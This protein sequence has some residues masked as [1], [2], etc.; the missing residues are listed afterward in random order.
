M[1]ESPLGC[2]RHA[3]RR[4]FGLLVTLG[5]GILLAAI[6]FGGFSLVFFHDVESTWEKHA[7]RATAI[8]DALTDLTEQIGYGGFIH[9]F[10]NLVLRRDLPRYEKRIE[11]NIT[12]LRQALD[13]LD[14][15]LPDPADQADL[16]TLRRTFEE[17]IRKYR[18]IP[19]MVREGATSTQL[20]TVVK[21]DDG[22]AFAALENLSTRVALRALKTRQMA[23]DTYS[24]AMSFDVIAGFLLIAVTLGALAGLLVFFRQLI[25]ANEEARYANAAKSEFLSS[26]SHELRTPLNAIL[27]F[28]QMLRIPD[29]SPLTPQQADNVKEIQ[30][31]GE[32]L[33]DLV[34]EVLDL[35]RIESGRIELSLEP[36]TITPLVTECVAQFRPL[37]EQ[38][39]ITIRMEGFTNN[40]AAHA[41]RARLKQVLLNLLSNAIKYNRECG[42]VMISA[43]T[44]EGQLRLSVM[45]T[46]LGIPPG[47]RTRLFKPFERLGA[48]YDGIEGTGIGLALVKRLVHA[49]GGEIGLESQVGTGSTF[50]FSLPIAPSQLNADDDSTG[51]GWSENHRLPEDSST[52]SQSAIGCAPSC[53]YDL[54]YIED[55]PA[56]LK[57]VRKI[58]A[59]RPAI[60]L[61]DAHNAELG[62]EMVHHQ[63]PDLILLD[64]S[65]PGMNGFEVLHLLKMD[66]ALADIPVIAVSA[67]A[68]KHDIE[69]G[70]AA[71]FC[72]YIFK[73]FE[74]GVFMETIDRHLNTGLEKAS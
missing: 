3:Y 28:T 52:L 68:M 17:Y 5:C 9:N 74:I 30:H 15:L 20:D 66:S 29:S 37:A 65:L 55:N 39:D 25:Q 23:Q 33:L 35:S 62:L 47:Q 7:T 56:N 27:G 46:G 64:L 41:D 44:A 57:L 31:A 60:S 11:A 21:V 72:D 36:V 58:L 22:P 61:R 67:N 2:A 71:G 32:H 73:P 54:L 26:M 69:R 50:W 14:I 16:A 34:N 19:P 4:Q 49:M 43:E 18:A 12:G 42:E 8:S 6:T 40:L 13:H 63:R 51:I 38:R 53:S 45:D 10:K 24:R 70:M 48:V 59:T 1:H